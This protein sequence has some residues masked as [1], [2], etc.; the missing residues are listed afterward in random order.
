MFAVLCRHNEELSL[1][2]EEMRRLRSSL[3]AAHNDGV[4]VSEERLQLHHENLQLRREMEELR[5]AT[6]L[7]QKKAKQEVTP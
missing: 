5:K 3:A 1:C 2:Q 7:V 4:S 6:M